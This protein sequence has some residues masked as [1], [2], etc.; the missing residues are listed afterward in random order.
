MNKAVFLD[1][2]G[3][4]NAIVYDREH[5]TLDSPANPQQ[6]ELLKGV[7]TAI[8]LLNEMGWLVVV[9]SNQPGIAKGKYTPRLLEAMNHKMLAELAGWKAHLDAIYYCLH[10]PQA[11]VKE[12]R[13]MC[14]CRKPLPGLLFK[15]RDELNIDLRKSYLVGDGL[16][17]VQAGRSAGCKTILLG[18]AR[19]YTCK[20]MSDMRARPHF[21]ASDLLTSV[22]LIQD[23]ESNRRLAP[24]RYP[25]MAGSRL[26]VAGCPT[27]GDNIIWRT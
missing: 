22:R 1:R 26:Q 18:R 14:G 17:D 4:I 13:K 16:I 21:V 25:E 15:G 6:F 27:P 12:Y 7:G 8:R 11:V 10:H 3:V 9:V 23:L 2:D 19:C 20:L 24:V 5:G